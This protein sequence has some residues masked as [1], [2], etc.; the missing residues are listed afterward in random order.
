MVEN[1]GT[2]ADQINYWGGGGDG[3]EP[4]RQLSAFRSSNAGDD[5]CHLL[6]SVASMRGKRSTRQVVCE[7]V[8][9]LT[10][11]DRPRQRSRASVCVH[12]RVDAVVE[13]AVVHTCLG[14]STC[15]P[16]A[17]VFIQLPKRSAEKRLKSAAPPFCRIR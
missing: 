11:T 5:S 13:R 1:R 16:A 10:G 12:L 14:V 6:D 3:N 4:K 7:P 2:G 15:A 9:F 8:H 17:A